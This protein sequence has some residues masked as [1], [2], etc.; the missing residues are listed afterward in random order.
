MSTTAI[1]V[2]FP[3]A[4][5]VAPEVT[6]EMQAQ[7][8]YELYGLQQIVANR[9]GLSLTQADIPELED[10]VRYII[11]EVQE[12]AA[13]RMHGRGLATLGANVRLHG[14][15]STLQGSTQHVEVLDDDVYVEGFIAGCRVDF[16]PDIEGEFESAQR[17]LIPSLMIRL[18][19][20]RQVLVDE[21][22]EEVVSEPIVGGDVYMPLAYGGIEPELRPLALKHA[23]HEVKIGGKV[24]DAYR[25]LF[26]HEEQQSMLQPQDLEKPALTVEQ[27]EQ[28]DEQLSN[29]LQYIQSIIEL[30]LE[31]E[32]KKVNKMTGE[33]I[34]Q[35]IQ[36]VAPHVV[37]AVEGSDV[38]YREM[39]FIS[40]GP[41]LMG[42]AEQR[43]H[44]VHTLQFVG[45]HDTLAG[46]FDRLTILPVPTPE[47]VEEHR[48]LEVTP[49]CDDS[50]ISVAAIL[51]DS[52]LY[53]G[54]RD[55]EQPG[56]NINYSASIILIP[57]VYKMPTTAVRL[58]FGQEL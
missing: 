19:D 48:T 45:H 42:I 25:G 35:F 37:S 8:V 55:G 33:E 17:W 26:A 50:T 56:P 40:S 41:G 51:K 5:R 2:S 32:G 3:D 52:R 34:E 58:D 47:W 13:Q 6:P 9:R 23:V 49:P 4:E 54:S 14:L 27:Q 36:D 22:G 38:L 53:S 30:R 39:P 24:I 43:G 31:A 1:E 29:F 57:V 10:D 15:V 28:H 46:I 44:R 7:F 16:L 18:R 21:D 11:N 20:A 12:A